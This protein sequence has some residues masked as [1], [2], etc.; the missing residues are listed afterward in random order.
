[1]EL[2][3]VYDYY[4]KVSFKDLNSETFNLLTKSTESN[5]FK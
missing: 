4:E 1:M 2:K 3:L 5:A